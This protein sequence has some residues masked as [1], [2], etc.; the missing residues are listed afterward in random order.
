[1]SDLKYDINISWKCLIHIFAFFVVFRCPC[2]TWMLKQISNAA[3]LQKTV[4]YISKLQQE[5]LQMQE[6]T[7]RLREEIEELNS[8]IKY[9]T[10]QWGLV[11]VLQPQPGCENAAYLIVS[12]NVHHSFAGKKFC[13]TADNSVVTNSQ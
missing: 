9:V 8:S 5:R 12:R 10:F 7:R 11:R 3:T 4:E 13:V 6:E 2:R 1:M